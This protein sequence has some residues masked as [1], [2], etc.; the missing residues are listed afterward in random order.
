[1]SKPK[2]LEAKSPHPAYS[3]PAMSFP[4]EDYFF[5]TTEHN[6]SVSYTL[7]WTNTPLIAHYEVT[8]YLVYWSVRCT[9]IWGSP[10]AM[11]GDA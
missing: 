5:T 9:R 2:I 1:M 6:C 11:E 8:E 3:E 4:I 7:F 10:I